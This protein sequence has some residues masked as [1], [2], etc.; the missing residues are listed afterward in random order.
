MGKETIWSPR[1]IEPFEVWGKV[2][3]VSY[4]L[5]L[6]PDIQHIHDVLH[7]SLLK[8]YKTDD[9]FELWANI[10]SVWFNTWRKAC[11]DCRFGISRIKD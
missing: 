1:Y 10:T 7:I 2:G 9:R 4:Q 11:G 8:A 6:P 5:V 3:A